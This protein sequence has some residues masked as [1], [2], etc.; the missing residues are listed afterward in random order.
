MTL[1]HNSDIFGIKTLL[2]ML[3]TVTRNIADSIA[4]EEGDTVDAVED[5][6][7]IIDEGSD[8]VGTALEFLLRFYS[9]FISAFFRSFFMGCMPG[10]V[11]AEISYNNIV[12]TR[13]KLF[14]IS[15]ESIFTFL[16]RLYK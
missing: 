11:M 15:C 16:Q 7:T 3:N 6:D 8:R 2:K 10:P 5:G 13:K 12:Q 1:P 9:F 14:N 4:Q